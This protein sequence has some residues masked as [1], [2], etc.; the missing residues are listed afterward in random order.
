[1]VNEK[2]SNTYIGTRIATRKT[3]IELLRIVAMLMIII[4]HYAIHG[5]FEFN[6]AF[7][8][9]HIYVDI[10]VF[11]GKTGANIFVLI[12]GYFLVEKGYSAKSLF[13]L[14]GEVWF[15]SLSIFLTLT[16]TGAI[17]FSFKNL[18]KAVIPVT[19]RGWWFISV[20]VVLYFFSPLLNKLIASLNK[21][22]MRANF[23]FLIV[24]W[25]LVPSV[26]GN[27]M[28]ITFYEMSFLVW[29]FFMYCVGAYLRLHE[30]NILTNKKRNLI[31]IGI[32]VC[33]MLFSVVFD[34]YYRSLANPN[35]V[36]TVLD[37]IA[38][39]FKGIQINNIIPFFMALSLFMIFTKIKMKNSIIVNLVSATTLGIY[40]LHDSSFRSVL[41][42]DT[43]KNGQFADSAFLIPHSILT[44][45]L[46]FVICMCIDF[47]RIVLIEIPFF[48]LKPVNKF[49]EFWDSKYKKLWE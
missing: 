41:W 31:F 26:L 6:D 44:T 25:C 10:L 18:V 14:L 20:Y 11:G 48:K 21:R 13:R 12:T 40:L 28:K 38:M 29:F 30:P 47:L 23:C 2:I 17:P 5:G 24:V 39:T 19:T 32:L 1:M 35:F 43:L 7:T 49:I 4:Q 45:L 37:Y 8:L 9:N 15:Y 36:L 27:F 33:A 3:S 22:Q 34:D 16:L 42:L 46:I